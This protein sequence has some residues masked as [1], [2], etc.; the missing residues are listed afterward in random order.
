MDAQ[1]VV[2]G[3][4]GKKDEERDWVVPTDGLCSGGGNREESVLLCQWNLRIEGIL[5]FLGIVGF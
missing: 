4:P 5:G 3:G 2:L 1:C